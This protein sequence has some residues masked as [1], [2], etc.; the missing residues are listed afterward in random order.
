[1]TRLQDL[2]GIE[3]ELSQ[4]G[5]A[6]RQFA[7]ELGA[8]VVGACHVTCSDEAETE[9]AEAFQR[10]F[11]REVLPELKPD[12][13]APLRSIN[14]G[15]RY[16]P[17]AIRVAEEHFATPQSRAAFKLLVV[18]INAHTA[19]HASAHGPEYGWLARYGCR[20]ACCGALA[21]LFEGAP[22]PAVEEFRKTFASDGKDR[23]AVLGDA[24]RVPA[25]HRALLTAVS[26]AALQARRAVQDIRQ[27]QPQTP[28]IF[29]V[30]PCVTINRPFEPDTEL[31]VGEY[32]IDRTQQEP[33][34]KHR[35]LGDD[36]AG[37][38]VRHQ[39][40][41]VVIEDDHWPAARG[42]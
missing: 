10:W 28:T 36:P 31:V 20:S 30:L 5:N 18:K 11:A 1:V 35:G 41:R 42:L 27:H 39:Q 14:L 16:E 21:G 12:S 15:G 38:R 17:G 23:L 7:Q 24:S 19:V 33:A 25:R 2:I 8:P 22:L 9:C 37:Y 34:I 26:S 4:V 13:R 40:G 3:N 32:G 6:L 29:L